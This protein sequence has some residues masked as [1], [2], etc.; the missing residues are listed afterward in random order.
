MNQSEKKFIEIHML[1]NYA[2]SNLNRDD[3][4]SVKDCTFGG[5]PRAR[6]SSQCR[7]RSIRTSEFFQ[8]ALQDKLGERTKFLPE[9]IKK[10]LIN[11]KKFSKDVATKWAE[12]FM[13]IGKSDKKG[14]N[15]E[16]K[17]TK[18]K[19]EDVKED[20]ILQTAQLMFYG[21]EELNKIIDWIVKNKNSEIP[22]KI[23]P[24]DIQKAISE[25][26]TKPVD[27]ALFGRM[28]T[29]EAFEDVNAACQVSHAIS[30]NQFSTDFDYFTA[31]DDLSNKYREDSGSAHLGET[32]FTSSCFYQYYAI[33]Y[34]AFVQSIGDAQLAKS[35]IAAFLKAATLSHPTGKQNSF[36]AHNPAHFIGIEIKS[37]K[38]PT[39]LANAF[40]KPVKPTNSTSLIEEA[41][42]KLAEY[43]VRNRKA[44]SLPIKETAVFLFDGKDKA[45][46]DFTEKVENRF[47][48]LDEIVSWLEKQLEA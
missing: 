33:D 29:L 41:S 48:T 34:D 35:A 6:I 5:Y 19:K 15:E 14:G 37:K 22:D 43:A 39:N 3:T 13:S 20:A 10:Y 12:K 32:E 38:I 26:K 25:L 11:E 2:P 31:V 24:K 47:D 45:G 30:V 21:K 7:K 44:F 18:K 46:K 27:I 1:Q 42:N 40:I 4:G 28:T 8:E 9:E 17:E 23:E 36:A 16:E